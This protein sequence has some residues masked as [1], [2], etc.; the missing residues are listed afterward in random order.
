[1]RRTSW[2]RFISLGLI[3][4]SIFA[5]QAFA[6]EK[7]AVIK[8]SMVNVRAEAN[9]NSKKVTNLYSNT[10]VKVGDPVQN[11]SGESWYPVNFQGGSGYIRSDFVKFPVQYQ[12]DEAFE[13]ALN[14]Q[15]FPEAYKDG[16]RALHAEFPNWQFKALHTNLDW[17]RV[18][19]GEMEGTGSLVDKNA[20]SSWKSTDQ[21]KY[22]W[23]TGTWVGFDGPTWVG[24]SRQ[25]TAY[26]MDPRNFL[27]ESYIFQFLLHSYNPEEQTRDGLS[28]VLKGSFMEGKG[29][30]DKVEGVQSSSGGT[31]Q[32]A[33]GAVVAAPGTEE[34][35][36]S[37]SSSGNENGVVSAVG[38][39]GNLSTS[40]NEGSSSEDSGNGNRSGIDYVDILMKAAEQTRQ[41]PYVLAAM[42]LQ[43]QGK[44]TSGSVSGASG[45]YNYFNVGAYAANG[46]GAVERGLWYAGQSGSYG[47]PWNSVEKSIV[48]GAVFFAE[49]YLKAGQNTLYLKKWNVQGANLYKHQYMTNVQGAAEEGAK[50]S[51]A[52]TAEMKNKAL[53]FSIPI[54]ENMPADKAA[55]PTGTGSPNNF[56]SSLSISGYSLNQAFEGAKQSYSVNIPSGTQS[57][58]IRAQAVDSK[59][60][61][62]GTGIQNLDGKSSLNISVKA[63]NGQDRIYTVNISYGEAKGSSTEQSASGRESGVEIIEV[64]KS[65]LS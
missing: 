58:D 7:D 41:N 8:G 54:Y 55:I 20:I 10:A 4:S 32:N 13:N 56:L 63:E 28:M 16:L 52:Y 14:Q 43:E 51:K 26:Y 5:T 21:G 11:S 17:Q 64:G 46:M 3:L 27:D 2:R 37:S 31:E 42:I 44:G 33:G 35:G 40:E 30:S 25:L 45:F 47:R 34:A 65:P 19:D 12:R 36:G 53:V 62:S 24:A 29:T 18:L 6:A 57:L 50:L 61:I 1:M 15:G 48:G 60:E 22:D 38:P 23:N 39:G 59:A 49:N 9:K